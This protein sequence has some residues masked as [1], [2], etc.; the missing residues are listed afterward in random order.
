MHTRTKSPSRPLVLVDWADE[1]G[2]RFGYSL[3][4]SSAFAGDARPRAVAGL[5]DAEG[6]T[7]RDVLAEHGVDIE[8]A[9]EC[10]ARREGLAAY[11]ELHIEQGP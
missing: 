7:M 2:A 6:R 9:P 8:R 3:F 5:Q 11:L 1:E 4:G 10:A